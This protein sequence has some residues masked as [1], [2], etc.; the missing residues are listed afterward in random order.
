L[1]LHRRD[2]DKNREI[3]ENFFVR[4]VIFLVRIKISRR[5]SIE[6]LRLLSLA[7]DNGYA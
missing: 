3:P 1:F 4:L 6:N 5:L 2:Y 7:E